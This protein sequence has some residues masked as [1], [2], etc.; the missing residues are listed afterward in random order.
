ME[1]KPTLLD[2][3]M[4]FTDSPFWN[5]LTFMHTNHL[6]M[7]S[8]FA[9]LLGSNYTLRVRYSLNS[10][11]NPVHLKSFPNALLLAH[12]NEHELLHQSCSPSGVNVPFL[13]VPM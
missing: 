12:G 9:F 5:T 8:N 6:T 1:R 4:S 10:V 7:P 13:T 2:F 11:A 3:M